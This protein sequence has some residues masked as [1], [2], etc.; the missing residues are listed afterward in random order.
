MK[1]RKSLQPVF[2]ANAPKASAT[3]TSGA[4]VTFR[5]DRRPD[6]PFPVK[7]ML[8]KHFPGWK[9]PEIS[10]ED[11]QAVKQ[12]DG[13]DAYPEL[14]QGDFDGDGQIDYAVLL[15]QR[16][17]IDDRDT[18]NS[19]ETCIVAFLNRHDRYKMRVVTREGGGCLQLM[20][21]GEPDYD[22]EAQRE[23]IYLHDTIMSGFGM[24]GTSYLYE[25]GKFRPI[26]TSD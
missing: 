19:P 25:K 17:I 22:Y 1:V 7:V 8:D 6:L 9:F 23:F 24:G 21:K 16:S 20:R 4:E 2:D 14:I 11:C 3:V 13:P 26:T 15:E 12:W 10:D 18:G 5:C